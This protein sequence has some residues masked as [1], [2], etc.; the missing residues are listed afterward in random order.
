MKITTFLISLHCFLGFAQIVSSPFNKLYPEVDSSDNYS[1]IVSGHF[2]GSSS[3]RSGFPANTL[4]AHL[5]KL[6]QSESAMMICL[7]DLF[8]DPEQ[9]VKNFQ[10]SLFDKL[11]M[12]LYN[13]VGNHDLT[14]FYTGKFGKTWY[15]F[16]LGN[17]LHIV[18]DTE[19]DNGNISG[20]QLGF[21]KGE[22]DKA[23]V[24]K[25]SNVFVYAHRT[26]WRD[27]YPELG[28]LFEDNTQ[29]TFE[30]NYKNE[31]LPLMAGISKQSKVWWFAGSIGSAPA[32]FFYH[33]DWDTDVTYIAT[34]IRELERDAVLKVSVKSGAVSFETMS[35]TGQD[36]MPLESYD[37]D[38]WNTHKPDSDFSWGLVPYYFQLALTHRYF[39]YGTA[40]AFMFLLTFRWIR[41]RRRTNT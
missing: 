31:I 22:C 24:R 18:L 32:S 29:S 11:K 12:P 37:V 13:A 5:D 15:S 3:N 1:F 21:L 30:S 4:L 7:G 26:I 10:W 39:W 17:D 27:S 23:E 2:H 36:L 16:V 38:Y 33:K 41:K 28:E 19:I 25:Y 9:D 8:M 14:D 34:A 35:L 20:D 6:N 40:F